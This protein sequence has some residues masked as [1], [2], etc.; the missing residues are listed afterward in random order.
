VLAYI[1]RR[2]VTLIPILFLLSVVSFFI[3]ELPPGDWVSFQIESLRMSGVQVS[4]DEALRLTRLYG[5]DKPAYERYLTWI[6]GIVLRGDLGWSFQWNRSVNAILAERVP[7]TVLISLLALVFSWAVAIPIGIYSATHQYSPGDYVF[8]FFGFIGLATPGFLLALV[9]A[10][11]F[12]RYFNFSALGLFSTEFLDEPWS[13][14]K[15]VD[16]LKH[17]WLPM[18]IVGL[19][20]TGATIRVMRNNLLDELQKQYVVTARAKGLT[21]LQ[22]LL[23]YPVRVAINPIIS[24]VGWVLPGIVAGE[25]LVAIV[26]S[27]QTVGPVLLRAVLAQ[28]MYLAGSIILILSTLTVIG[29]LLSDILLAWLDPRIRYGG[30]GK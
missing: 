3:I 5:L 29:T 14:A 10:W 19:A 13:W 23:K 25:I 20:G 4:E 27:L 28:D 17:I 7:L 18:I 21:E 30:V 24:T 16:M 8:T 22:I 1:A 6:G 11:A 26:L 2:V 15:F 9:L 12:F